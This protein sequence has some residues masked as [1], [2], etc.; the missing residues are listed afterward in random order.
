M[1]KMAGRGEL[2]PLA[3]YKD[4]L[5]GILN[6]LGYVKRFIDTIKERWATRDRSRR[7]NKGRRLR[8]LRS[9]PDLPTEYEKLWAMEYLLKIH[10]KNTSLEKW[11]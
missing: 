4:K 5:E 7:A 11:R 9:R 3:Q 10:S 6:V 2:I 1:P 8:G